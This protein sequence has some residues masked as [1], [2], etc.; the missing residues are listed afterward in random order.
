MK[1]AALP[2]LAALTAA[3][4]ALW[5]CWG[6][7]QAQPLVDPMRPPLEHVETASSA[8][9]PDEPVLQSVMITPTLRAAIIN[10]ETVQLGGRFR[11]AQVIKISENEVVLKSGTET[12]ILKMYPGVEKREHVPQTP[13]ATPGGAATRKKAAAAG[14]EDAK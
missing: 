13:K 3:S 10:G 1:R 4:F 12:Q 14:K 11:E 2:E 7:A 8:P 6:A 9:A 5:F